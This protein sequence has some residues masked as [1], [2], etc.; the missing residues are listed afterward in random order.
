M[1]R[2]IDQAAPSVRAGSDGPLE[3]SRDMRVA[4]YF[5]ISLKLNKGTFKKGKSLYM[6]LTKMNFVPANKNFALSSAITMLLELRFS[7]NSSIH[8]Y[9]AANECIYCFDTNQTEPLEY[10]LTEEHIIPASLGAPLVLP[11]ASCPVHQKVTSAIETAVVHRIFDPTRKHFEIRNRNGRVLRKGNFWCSSV[12]DGKQVKVRLPIAN[13][14]TVLVL[15]Q[16]MPPGILTARPK[17]IHGI[18]GVWAANLNAESGDLG[19]RKLDEFVAGEIDTLRF[20]Q[21]LAKI[22]HS[23]AMAKVSAEDFD[24]L[25]P[26]FIFS[27]DEN[28]SRQYDLIGGE[29]SVVPP[30][31][32]LHELGLGIVHAADDRDYLVARIRLFAFL[33]SPVY[34]AVV[35]PVRGGRKESLTAR[36]DAK[37]SHELRCGALLDLDLSHSKIYIDGKKRKFNLTLSI[38]NSSKTAAYVESISI[39]HHLDREI[40]KVRSF[41]GQETRTTKLGDALLFPEHALNVDSETPFE[42]SEAIWADVQRGTVVYSVYGLVRYK[43]DLGN[44]TQN[45]FGSQVKVE[46]LPNNQWRCRLAYL[47]YRESGVE[48]DFME[49]IWK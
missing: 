4:R 49:R 36:L 17:S 47:Q 2:D 46:N 7:T 40:S 33:G 20:T 35:G 3:G 21:M 24:P 34:Y 18:G 5:R 44:L 28:D 30:L 39:R 13:H 1:K 42:I 29:E 10:K 41:E 26:D 45:G 48:H 12:G 43:D 19:A 27:A 23:F 11:N 22:A 38:R 14:P 31:P 32:Y 6:P 16:L 15:L 37:N 9:D 25:L 8:R